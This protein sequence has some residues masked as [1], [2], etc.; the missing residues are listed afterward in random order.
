LRRR[1]LANTTR[2]MP[3]SVV[4]RGAV[5]VVL[6]ELV[7]DEFAGRRCEGWSTAQPDRCSQGGR[8][9]AQ[10]CDGVWGCQFSIWCATYG[11]VGV[12]SRTV[13]V[14]RTAGMMIVRRVLGAFGCGP[15][16]NVDAVEIAV[17]CRQLPRARYTPADRMLLATLA[18]LLPR[19]RWPVFLVTPA[20]LLRRHRVLVAREAGPTLPSVAADV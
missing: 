13:V 2:S 15:T 16:P 20:T 19:E 8:P 9:S 6:E 10:D 4:R 1:S 11:D 7:L 18:K 12:A 17:L 14:V 5:G 3:E